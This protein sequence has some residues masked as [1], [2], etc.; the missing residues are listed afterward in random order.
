LFY[1]IVVEIQAQCL[2]NKVVEQLIFLHHE[3]EA[4][5]ALAETSIAQIEQS[6]K[7]LFFLHIM[8]L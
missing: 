1:A 4:S 7:I 5:I 8:T 6:L 3:G 2:A